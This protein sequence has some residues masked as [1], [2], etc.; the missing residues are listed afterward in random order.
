MNNKWDD[1]VKYCSAD[2][3]WS[4]LGLPEQHPFAGIRSVEEHIKLIPEEARYARIEVL[5]VAVDEKQDKAFVE[6]K[7]QIDGKDGTVIYTNDVALAVE[8]K[9]DKITSIREYMD[10]VPV[11]KYFERIKN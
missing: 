10:S 1:I 2:A 5:S 9:G 3:Q 6:L 7:S 11:Q 8:F 4:N